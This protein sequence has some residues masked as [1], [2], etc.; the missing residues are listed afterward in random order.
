MSLRHTHS[1]FK[2]LISNLIDIATSAIP[3][4]TRILALMNLVFC[5][6]I[7]R[8]ICQFYFSLSLNWLVV[9]T[10]NTIQYNY[11]FSFSWSL[12][13]SSY[14]C[15]CFWCFCCCDFSSFLGACCFF[16][17]KKE[18]ILLVCLYNSKLQKIL[19]YIYKGNLHFGRLTNLLNC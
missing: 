4:H 14:S 5:M 17:L 15:A 6:Q 8:F 10:F 9:W 3:Y 7:K 2:N 13:A 1:N 16:P 18:N 11:S 12:L 19:P